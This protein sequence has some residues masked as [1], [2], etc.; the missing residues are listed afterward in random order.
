M[1]VVSL[2]SSSSN[3]T[4]A[5]EESMSK[6]SCPVSIE[7][8][9]ESATNVV[10]S[11]FP[12]LISP[13]STAS[14]SGL[15]EANS[16]SLPSKKSSSSSSEPRPTNTSPLKHEKVSTET[17]EVNYRTNVTSLFTCIENCNWQDCSMQ[18]QRYPSHVR[19]WVISTGTDDP[20]SWC[21]WRRL[22]IHEACRRQPPVEII[23]C[24]LNIFPESAHEKTQF[25]ELPVHLAAGCGAG[26]DVLNLLLSFNPLAVLIRDNGGRTP[27]EIIKSGL[28][29]ENSSSNVSAAFLGCQNTLLSYKKQYQQKIDYIRHQHGKEINLQK[30]KAEQN[31]KVKEDITTQLSKKLNSHKR[32]IT[33]LI[34]TMQLC[35]DKIMEKNKAESKLM[36]RVFQLENE[37]ASIRTENQNLKASVREAHAEAEEK[38]ENIAQLSH[39]IST[40][41]KDMQSLVEEKDKVLIASRKW[42]KEAA[43]LIDK[44]QKLNSEMQRQRETLRTYN[45]KIAK[46]SDHIL[47]SKHFTKTWNS[48]GERKNSSNSSRSSKNSDKSTIRP[49]LTK[50]EKEDLL[51]VATSSLKT[52]VE[53][54]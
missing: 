26:D 51:A 10:S 9:E 1:V 39:C 54:E 23:Q 17:F 48:Y 44:Q 35:E 11:P 3:S 31:L 5:I 49:V 38:N 36:T 16:G 40:L 25:G 42:E 32:Q 6:S 22:P 21:V 29:E 13:S 27:L 30:N 2:K 20:S 8:K 18:C 19:T 28:N 33:E 43:E 37:N 4:S 52:K 34:S 41:L 47:N 24:L 45:F 46:S 15:I 50:E 12:T 7:G 53:N 14:S